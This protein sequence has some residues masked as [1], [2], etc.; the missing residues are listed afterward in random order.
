[1]NKK[2][3]SKLILLGKSVLWL[4]NKLSI[5]KASLYNKLNGK[6]RFTL[7]EVRIITDVLELT[8]E[9]VIYIFFDNK[10]E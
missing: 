6:T 2:I 9:E 3:K 1:M 10:V 7:D 4:A 5:S 8:D